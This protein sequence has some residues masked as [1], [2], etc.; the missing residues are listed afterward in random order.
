MTQG[1]DGISLAHRAALRCR[2]IARHLSVVTLMVSI[3][4]LVV[5]AA[6]KSYAADKK[7]EDTVVVSNFGVL[8]AGSVE[9]FAAG[10]V[11]NAIPTKKIKGLATTLGAA[12]GASG[13]AQSSSPDHEI[14]VALTLGL[15]VKCPSDCHIDPV[16]GACSPRT[17]FDCTVGSTPGAVAV[18]T[19]GASGNTA[20]EELID[21]GFAEILNNTVGGLAVPVLLNNTGMFFP[22]GVS[23]ENPFARSVGA[24]GSVSTGPDI[25]AVANLAPVIVGSTTDFIT[26]GVTTLPTIGTINFY[27]EG[28]TGNIAPL[29]RSSTSSSLNTIF[30]VPIPPSTTNPPNP[31]SDLPIP[32]F[33]NASIGGC[34]TFLFLPQGIAFDKNNFLWVVN[35]GTAIS[36]TVFIP[37]FVSAFAPDAAA[38]GDATPVDILGLGGKTPVGTFTTPLFIAVGDDPSGA[39]CGVSSSG[40]SLSSCDEFIFVT[41][42]GS[43]AFACTGG[44]NDGTVCNNPQD[45]GHVCLGGGVCRRPSPFIGPSV[46]ILDV[47]LGVE[48]GAIAGGS[49]KLDRPEGVALAGDDLYVVNSNSNTLVM[50]DDFSTS[51]GN[52]KPKVTISGPRTGLNFPTGVALP[53]FTAPVL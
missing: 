14:A 51:G 41:D 17:Q 6:G 37:P 47:T 21:G 13:L 36:P 22:Q 11:H 7:T 19:P 28:D 16:N 40:P 23:F 15:P 53:E 12:N 24:S 8:F 3:A 43:P 26:C 35:A 38:V 52:I 49:T 20:P 30:K 32:Y 25:F 33:G 18:F 31:P 10:S 44:S 48:T 50:F 45:T 4:A 46:K 34:S 27:Q 5:G 42:A 39:T 9:T 2:A 1:N 29:P